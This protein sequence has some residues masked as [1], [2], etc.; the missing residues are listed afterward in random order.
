MSGP[1]PVVEQDIVCESGGHELHG[2]LCL[3][4]TRRQPPVVLMIHGSGPLD[5][6]ANMPGQQFD[7]FNSLAHALAAAGYASLRYDK[8]G[9]GSSTGDF[10]ETGHAGGFAE[11]FEKVNVHGVSDVRGARRTE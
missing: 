11:T 8:R 5:R 6:N 7:V 9:C 2:T 4:A 10:F 3:P 1:P